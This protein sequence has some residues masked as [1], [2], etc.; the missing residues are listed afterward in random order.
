MTMTTDQHGNQITIASPDALARYDAMVDDLLHYRPAV[1][2][3]LAATLAADP[4][5]AMA[6]AAQ[7]HLGILGT[8]PDDVAAARVAL[9]AYD[10]VVDLDAL[11][12]RER[13]HL[14]AA[15]DLVRGDL[16]AGAATLREI[17]REHPRDALA[18]LVGHQ[19]DFF[20]GD[21]VTLRDRV[22][23]AL[24]AWS[25]ADP[26]FGM[27][28]GMY[29]FGLE[30]T[31]QYGRAE[32]VGLAS[33]E[34]DGTDVWGIHAVTHTF[35]MQGRFGEGLRYL[36]AHA[37]GW[38]HDNFLTVHNWWHYCLYL[39]EVGDADSVLAIYDSVLHHA[40]SQCVAMEMLDAAALLWRMYLEGKD[41]SARWTALADAWDAKM[42]E[43]YYAFNDMHAVMSY[44]GAGRIDD[45][46]RLVDAR[47]R[48]A[49]QAVDDTVTNVAMTRGVG[50]PV[51]RALVAFGRG[52]YESAVQYLFPIRYVLHRFGGSH[53]QRDAVQRTLVEAA[54]RSGR[55]SL[56][57][58][59]LSERLG[60]NPCSPYSWLKQA[61]LAQALGDA[62]AEG[63]A[64]S[65]ATELR[66]EAR[67]A[68]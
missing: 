66:A 46:V 44:V 42:A 47:E 14:A 28:Q 22:G 17:V 67:V 59:L 64:R 9:D 63:A 16:Y 19:V 62:A 52:D 68:V 26:H 54:L 13:M 61:A 18:L 43:P 11:T 10:Q 25:P 5:C 41:E 6:H 12:S 57:R 37:A 39:L 23:G 21:A 15:R 34:H 3:T 27:L 45:A 35:E 33:V 65:R 36:D 7:A 60:V 8:E 58:S 48:F 2:D 1:V 32:E 55:L 56:A 49:A 4:S 50:V 53:A 31:G 38:R 24:S 40:E 51:G 30:E 29:A 20:T